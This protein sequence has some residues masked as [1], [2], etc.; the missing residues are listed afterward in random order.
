MHGEEK[1]QEPR[2]LTVDDFSASMAVAMGLGAVSEEEGLFAH[3][4]LLQTS[5]A[6]FAK[7][8]LRMDVGDFYLAISEEINE[9]KRLA[10]Q[11]ARDT[12]KSALFS[13]AFAIWMAWRFPGALGY[14]F[15]S[16]HGL[17][18]DL[19][20]IIKNGNRQVDPVTGEEMGLYALADIPELADLVDEKR[21]DWAKN[22]IEL[23]NGSRIRARGW[24]RGAIRGPHPLWA[25][26]DDVLKE[27]SLWSEL[28]REK[29]I[30]F[31]KTAVTNMLLRGGWIVVVGTP[32]HEDDLYGWVKQNKAYKF[33]KFPGIMEFHPGSPYYDEEKG[34]GVQYRSLVPN[35]HTVAELRAKREEIGAVAFAREIL[36]EPITD[37]LTLFPSHLFAGDVMSHHCP[38]QPSLLQCHALGWETYIGVDIAESAD[39]GADYFVVT[40][41]ALDGHGNRYIIDSYRDRGVGFQRQLSIIRDLAVKYRPVLVYV[42]SNAMQRI[43]SEELIRTTELPIKAFHVGTNKNRLS[44]GVPSL[45]VLLENEKLRLS[46]ST[47]EAIEATDAYIDEMKRFGWFQGKLQ[48]A[49]SHDDCVMSL[50]IAIEATR[51]ATFKY[52]MPE[53]DDLGELSRDVLNAED[54]QGMVN[55]AIRL[56][57]NG[58]EVTCGPEHY[59]VLRDALESY[60]IRSVDINRTRLVYAEIARLDDEFGDEEDDLGMSVLTA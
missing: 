54:E 3:E 18:C 27:G 57:A 37:D 2:R 39:V 41:L 1:H 29:A 15:S 23:T 51:D 10:V 58:G 30:N 44:V 4:L 12:G 45:R 16:T 17:A 42:E 31:L 32:F 28:E 25:V 24:E 46:R 7:H 33:L 52:Y 40:V 35:R 14:I 36:C 20:S 22:E 60:A 13:Y 56:V 19:L 53:Q 55:A 34:G 49:G 8:I 48:G 47:P 11:A 50:W 6:Y 5:L 59:R 38:W 26:C 43:W 9:Q 21:C